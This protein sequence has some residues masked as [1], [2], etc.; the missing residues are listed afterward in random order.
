[1]SWYHS[2]LL[3]TDRRPSRIIASCK[4]F[5]RRVSGGISRAVR[6][7]QVPGKTETRKQIIHIFMLFIPNRWSCSVEL[8]NI[9]TLV[10]L[11]SIYTSD[12]VKNNKKNQ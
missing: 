4:Q 7:M 6:R 8:Y 11:S 1:M 3:N 5:S 9:G 2:T 10:I 12:R